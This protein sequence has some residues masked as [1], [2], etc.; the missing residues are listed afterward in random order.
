MNVPS[1]IRHATRI[2]LSAIIWLLA[3]FAT[4]CYGAIPMITDDTG[5]QGRGKFQIEVLGEYTNDKES[6]NETEPWLES[7]QNG[8]TAAFTYGIIDPV[9]IVVSMPYQFLE[10]D[11]LPGTERTNGFSDTAVEVKWRFFE[12]EGFSLAMKPGITIPTGDD[13]KGLGA[14]KVTY[15]LYLIASQELGPWAFHTNLAYI[16]NENKNDE[17]SDIL[18]ASLATTFE[19]VEQIKLVGDIGVES[20]PDKSDTTPPAYAL[21]G[22]IFS[23]TKNFD[24]GLGA[25]WGLTK[26]ETDFSVRG[27]ITWRF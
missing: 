3:A 22:L 6:G 12:K 20:N 17:R 4:V 25:R 14:G 13:K 2:L 10:E 18:F 16:R 9:D 27:G 1:E 8:V 23:P 15:Y 24:I 26:P 7:S 19:V 21:G 11:S 5:T